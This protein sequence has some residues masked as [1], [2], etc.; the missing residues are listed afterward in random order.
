[1]KFN[2]EGIIISQKKYGENSMIVKVFSQEYGFYRGFV[3]SIKSAKSKT[4][5]QI[6]NLISF[7][8]RSRNEENLGQFHRVDLDKSFCSK[9]MFDRA[10]LECV[11]A[12]FSILDDVFL[13]RE[14]Q[15]TLFERVQ[16]FLKTI[17]LEEDKGYLAEYVRLELEILK[18]LGYEIDLSCCVATESTENLAFVS[19]KSARAVS[20]EAGEPYRNKLLRLPSFLMKKEGDVD[21]EDL[22]DGLHLTG[23]F[24]EK[25]V[26][27]GRVE[28]MVVRKKLG[29]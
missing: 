20:R 4:I 23:Y 25:F 22:Q 5:F 24:L 8:Y 13:E 1:M 29:V 16:Y 18:V 6:G 26:Y 15:G 3:K 17:N 12:L 10:R 21:D 11:N 7:E 28:R 27:E 19:P 9:I 14:S 2:D